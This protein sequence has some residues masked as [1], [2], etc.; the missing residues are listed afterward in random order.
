MKRKSVCTKC[1]H[2]GFTLIREKNRDILICK[3]CKDV[4]IYQKEKGE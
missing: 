4:T 1:G 3:K 2:R